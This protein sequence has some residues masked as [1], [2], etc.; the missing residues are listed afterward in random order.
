MLPVLCAAL[1]FST[2]FK[3]TSST[4][5]EHQLVNHRRADRDGL[6]S[7]TRTKTAPVV[8]SSSACTICTGNLSP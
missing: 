3:S 4:G 8:V 2:F 5:S 1:F 7:V 6:G